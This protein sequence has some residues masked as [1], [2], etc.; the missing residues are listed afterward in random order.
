MFTKRK[1][2]FAI[3]L[4]FGLMMCERPEIKKS[5]PIPVPSPIKTFPPLDSA[6]TIKFLPIFSTWNLA[7]GSC[8][9]H[10]SS[11]NYNALCPV[12]KGRSGICGRAEVGCV[13][14]AMSIVMRYWQQPVSYNWSTMKDSCSTK[15]TARLMHDAGLSVNMIYDAHSTTTSPG[16]GESGIPSMSVVPSAFLNTFNYSTAKYGKY[17]LDT[18]L[19]EIDQGRPVVVSACVSNGSSDYLC[20][21]WII[22]GYAIDQKNRYYL[23]MNWGLSRANWSSANEWKATGYDQV[24]N[25]KQD[26]VYNIKP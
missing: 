6:V 26:M 19:N 7:C 15:E 9:A 2:L 16:D 13:A 22:N 20:H 14:V 3:L 12:Y 5:V 11:S 17:N 23:F 10:D 24:F 1:F 4:L 8:N 25:D 18:L 21:A